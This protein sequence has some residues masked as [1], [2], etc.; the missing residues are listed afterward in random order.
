MD[1]SFK[2][3][4][5]PEWVPLPCLGHRTVGS[6]GS[7]STR[8]NASTGDTVPLDR[9]IFPDVGF[10]VYAG[11]HYVA[12]FTMVEDDGGYLPTTDEEMGE[13]FHILDIGERGLGIGTHTARS[14]RG[15]GV[16]PGDYTVTYEI[17]RAP[18]PDLN[19]G[20]IRVL[21]LL[22][23]TKKLVCMGVANVELTDAGPF[24]VA[25]YIDNVAP[26][27]GRITAGSLAAG[28]GGELCVEAQLPTTGQH[29]LKVV[30]DEPRVV[31]EYNEKNN[32][33]EQP[34]Q[35]TGAATAP[36]STSTPSTAQTNLPHLTV[37]AIRVNGQAPDGKN[38]CKDGKNDIAV[39]VK[40]T[41]TAE[42]ENVTVR[43]IVDDAQGSALEQTVKGLD[44]GQERE[45]RFEDVRL[46]KGQHTLTAIVDPKGSVAETRDDN[47]ALKVTAGCAAG[48]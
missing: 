14:V 19:P 8:F 22:G 32:V 11:Y 1:L 18:L 21:D 44:A 48:D 10:P 36:T 12:R 20:G 2:I 46:K 5:C 17:R 29:Q 41:G 40:N 33:Y 16:S 47:N 7:G 27:D 9:A 43:L 42:S 13:V 28:T 15:D 24:E 38:D 6:I 25:L 37:S 35:A 31:V 34:Y 4:S 26:P 30:V 39:V 45:V 23:S 3:W